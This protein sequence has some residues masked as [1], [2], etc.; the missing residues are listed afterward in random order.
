MDKKSETIVFNGI[1]YRRYPNSKK[2]SERLYYK[3]SAYKRF[4]GTTGYL[5]REVWEHHN[6]PIPEGYSIHHKNGYDDNSI[7]SLELVTA[8]EHANHHSWGKHAGY[9]EFLDEIR[10]L[11]KEWHGSPAGL[12]WHSDNGKKSWLTRL[13]IVVRCT[14]C[15]KD[16]ETYFKDRS[17]YCSGRCKATS[18]RRKRGVLPKD[19]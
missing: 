13:P 11:T 6:G 9:K 10:P 4:G 2:R 14:V 1:P 19:K 15:N 7:E 16:Y 17:K 8:K 12:E 18:L 5:H 3:R